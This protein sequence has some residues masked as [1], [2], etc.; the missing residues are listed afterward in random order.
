M[1]AVKGQG[2]FV[3]DCTVVRVTRSGFDAP[4]LFACLC[5]PAPAHS[6]KGC[7]SCL[8]SATFHYITGMYGVRLY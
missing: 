5:S 1:F 8:S 7:I 2:N 4:Q 6:F 3:R